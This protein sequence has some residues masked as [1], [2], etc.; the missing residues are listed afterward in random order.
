RTHHSTERPD[1]H[2]PLSLQLRN[3]RLANMK[4][5]RQVLLRKSA[6]QPNSRDRSFARRIGIRILG[7]KLR[8]TAR[9]RGGIRVD[10][11]RPF[12][13]DRILAPGERESLPWMPLD[14]RR[15]LLVGGVQKP[16]ASRPSGR[17]L[18]DVGA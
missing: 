14:H 9:R 2:I 8:D 18:G 6:E 4:A 1:L 13:I 17:I 11:V 10:L 5:F 7:K 15:T 12:S 3:R 16:D